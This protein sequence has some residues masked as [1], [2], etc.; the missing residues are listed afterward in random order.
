MLFSWFIFNNNLTDKREG[1]IE[2][3]RLSPQGQW[4]KSLLRMMYQQ[5]LRKMIRAADCI[6]HKILSPV[7]I[8][9]SFNSISLQLNTCTHMQAGG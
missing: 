2:G 1:K 8:P 9:N 4:R 3:M 5:E 6:Y 7:L